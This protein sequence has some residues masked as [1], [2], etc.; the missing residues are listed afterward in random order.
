MERIIKEFQEKFEE[1]L[2][3]YTNSNEVLLT[4][5]SNEI[6]SLREENDYLKKRI[7]AVEINL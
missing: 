7:K 4:I 1:H 6:F 3:M 2:E 5:L